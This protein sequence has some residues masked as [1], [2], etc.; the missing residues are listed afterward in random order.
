MQFEETSTMQPLREQANFL[1]D[2][3][4]TNVHDRNDIKILFMMKV[5]TLL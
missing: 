2:T 1:L 3:S 4:S 5:Q